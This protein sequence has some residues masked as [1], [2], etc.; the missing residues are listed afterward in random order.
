VRRPAGRGLR[1]QGGP[2]GD[3]AEPARQRRAPADRAGLA[4]Q[5]QEGGLESVLGVRLVAQHAPADVQHQALV[6][7]D[8]QLE[9]R[10]VAPGHELFQELG[11]RDALAA[12]PADEV[13]QVPEEA[14]RLYVR[15]ARARPRV[16]ACLLS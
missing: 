16:D 13:A 12:V 1:P 5:R 2:V 11:V 15:H 10:L 6:P 3:P 8:E 14:V 7:P 4:R 9:G